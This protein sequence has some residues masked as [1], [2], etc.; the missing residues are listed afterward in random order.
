[1]G[2]TRTIRCLTHRTQVGGLPEMKGAMKSMM[3]VFALLALGLALSATAYA[4]SSVD[5]SPGNDQAGQIQAQVE[6]G[7]PGGGAP[8]GGGPGE[9]TPVA[10][11]TDEGG[12]LPFTGLDMALLAGAGGLLAAAGLAM[13]RLTRAPDA[14]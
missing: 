11:D 1:M 5:G 14:A 10:A 7:G 6:Q 2:T 12:S 4:Q 3:L 13:R 8:G 9:T